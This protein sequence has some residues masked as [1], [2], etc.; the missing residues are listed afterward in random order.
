MEEEIKIF[1]EYVGNFDLK[2]ERILR[3]KEH[4]YRVMN[5]AKS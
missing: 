5:F 2:D 3:K 4:S 1:D